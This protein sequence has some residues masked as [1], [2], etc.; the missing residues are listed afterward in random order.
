MNGTSFPICSA[1]LPALERHRVWLKDLHSENRRLAED[2][3]RK[4]EIVTECVKL[5]RQSDRDYRGWVHRREHARRISDGDPLAILQL[6]DLTI[7]DLNL[8]GG[9]QRDPGNLV[10]QIVTEAQREARRKS[11]GTARRY[12]NRTQMSSLCTKRQKAKNPV[13]EVVVSS[14]LTKSE[15]GNLGNLL[16]EGQKEGVSFDG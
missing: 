7:S 10:V 11:I 4:R 16:S 15:N 12:R 5:L 13:S 9:A 1:I 2:L 14:G 6:V 3:P 8:H